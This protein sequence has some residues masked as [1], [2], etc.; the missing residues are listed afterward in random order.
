MSHAS[1]SCDI[2][3]IVYSIRLVIMLVKV[4]ER[5]H[6]GAAHKITSSLFTRHR[7]NV[8]DQGFKTEFYA[9]LGIGE[10]SSI[11][12]H[13]AEL[14]LF[15]VMQEYNSKG[16]VLSQN[17]GDTWISCVC[18]CICWSGNL[19]CLFAITE[20]TI[21]KPSHTSHMNPAVRK[22]LHLLRAHLSQALSVQMD[23]ALLLSFLHKINAKIL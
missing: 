10:A 17:S 11:S 14:N 23:R 20:G 1:D 6:A 2:V 3:T 7:R 21:H 9:H 8:T 16:P 18:C 22:C 19:N 4:S 13:E 5:L 15:S 12:G